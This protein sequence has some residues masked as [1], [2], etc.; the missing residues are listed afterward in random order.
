[1]GAISIEKNDINKITALSPLREKAFFTVMRQ[2]G[3]TPNAIRK[4]KMK[5]LEP[6][7]RIPCKIDLPQEPRKPHAF[8]IGEEAIRYLKQYLATRKNLTPE[9]LLFTI[10]GNPNKEINTKDVSRT[11]RQ[12]AEKLKAKINPEKGKANKLKL[13]NLINFYR[14][15]A[16]Y[17]LKEMQNNPL[18]DVEFYRNLYKERAMPFL[19]IED[20]ITI[21]LYK[22]KKQYQKEIQNQNNQIKEMRQTIAKDNEY[23]SSIL[24]LL[25]NNKGD[26]ETGEAEKLGDDF[27]EL[28]KKT[29]EEQRRNLVESWDGKIEFLPCK[30][31]LEEL[32]KTLESII[33]PYEKLRKT[34]E[35]NDHQP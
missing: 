29:A 1:L 23:I 5:N 22:P 20:Q 35:A 24:S 14:D 15:N 33:K 6:S 31:I 21:Q 7:T 3:L 26:Y 9:S 16:K 27:I 18:E 8:F 19:E 30:D 11:F 10:H 2:S 32:T 13:F 28:W 17:Y 4:L 12:A 25:Y 34:I